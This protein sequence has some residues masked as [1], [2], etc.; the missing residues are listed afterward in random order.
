MA[1]EHDR[2]K[3]LEAVER[4]L[5]A[6]ANRLAELWESDPER[7]I[8]P[9]YLTALKEAHKALA[10]GMALTAKHVGAGEYKDEESLVLELEKAL[11]QVKRRMQ[12]GRELE[13]MPDPKRGPVQ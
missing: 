11:A 2:V 3:A 12:L 1:D 10:V 5:V 8:P 4:R 7:P 6:A 13:E 9:G